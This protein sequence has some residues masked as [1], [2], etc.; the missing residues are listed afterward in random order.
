MLIIVFAG[1]SATPGG[2][3]DHIPTAS[4]AA[5]NAARVAMVAAIKDALAPW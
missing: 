5:C 1:S 3:I 4:E 2:G